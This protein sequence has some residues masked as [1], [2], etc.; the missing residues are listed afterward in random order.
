[1]TFS[2]L[3]PCYNVSKY[4]EKCLESVI[5]QTYTDWEV[6]LIDDGSTD[7]TIDIIKFYAEKEKRIKAFYQK[8]NQGV[9]A[10]RNLLI[11]ESTGNFIIF[12]PAW[13]PALP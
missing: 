1:M 6:I 3:I 13:I 7:G 8:E 9:S 5:C 4:I 10:I 12:L 2:I 11:K